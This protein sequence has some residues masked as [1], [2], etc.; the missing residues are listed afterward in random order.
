MTHRMDMTTHKKL[1]YAHKEHTDGQGMSEATR[2]QWS[3]KPEAVYL[4]VIGHTKVE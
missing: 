4:Q 1:T 3:V 2:G